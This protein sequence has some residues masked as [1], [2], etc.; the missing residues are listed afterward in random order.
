M[1]VSLEEVRRIAALARLELSPERAQVAA[2][3]LSTILAHMEVL[4]EVDTEGV[5]ESLALGVVGPATRVDEGPPVVLHASISAIAPESRDGFF[6]VPRLA[7]HEHP[8]TTP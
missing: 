7:T 3:E 2:G 1:S 5:S 6:L 8:E 4:T